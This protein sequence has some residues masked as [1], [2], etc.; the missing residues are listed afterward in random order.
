MGKWSL[1]LVILVGFGVACSDE[2]EADETGEVVE[3]S[4]PTE[5]AKAP[6]MKA[7]GCN[8]SGDFHVVCKDW[9]KMMREG[10]K[11][12]GYS[13]STPGPGSHHHYV[14]FQR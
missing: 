2:E 5:A 12:V 4:A 7:V 3:E 8:G 14:L 1:I 6:E 13:T 11:P 10:W 9:Q